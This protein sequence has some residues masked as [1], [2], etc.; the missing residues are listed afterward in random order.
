MNPCEIGE[1]IT[2]TYMVKISRPVPPYV[3][4]ATIVKVRYSRLMGAPALGYVEIPSH[5]IVDL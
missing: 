5:T 3:N 2:F 1:G 4:N